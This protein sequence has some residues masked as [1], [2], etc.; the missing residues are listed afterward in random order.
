[1]ENLIKEALRRALNAGMDIERAIA[2][3]SKSHPE[4]AVQ[5]V[6]NE[7]SIRELIGN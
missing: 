5:S 2:Y 7:T 3:V 4:Q 6:V 1:M